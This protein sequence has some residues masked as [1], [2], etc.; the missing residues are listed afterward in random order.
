MSDGNM[1]RAVQGHATN[2]DAAVMNGNGGDGGVG[3]VG[4]VAVAGVAV[5]GNRGG[6]GEAGN[7]AAIGVGRPA[8]NNR[9]LANDD[10]EPHGNKRAPGK[11]RARPSQGTE[12]VVYRG[13]KGKFGH[14]FE[15]FKFVNPPGKLCY[16]KGNP[17]QKGEKAQHAVGRQTMDL[18]ADTLDSVEKLI[19]ESGVVSLDCT[20]WPQCMKAKE[21]K[22]R[23]EVVQGGYRIDLEMV[24]VLSAGSLPED[25]RTFFDLHAKLVSLGHSALVG[26]RMS[27]ARAPIGLNEAIAEAM[28]SQLA[29][30]AAELQAANLHA[31]S[32]AHSQPVDGVTH[33]TTEMLRDAL[34]QDDGSDVTSAVASYP[35]S[36][37][38]T[39]SF[40]VQSTMHSRMRMAER[41]ITKGELQRAVKYAGHLARPGKPSVLGEPTLLIE[42]DGVVYCTDMSKKI[43]I[44][45]WRVR[46]QAE[47]GQ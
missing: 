41:E 16:A 12:V 42:Y 15:E 37:A 14:R 46:E 28:D 22:I 40:T 20:S 9:H 25:Q 23:L 10:A 27:F 13:H 7:D 38:A 36:I 24:D 45:N 2:G 34:S 5:D 32:R 8:N 4:N 44:S 33:P 31:S 29:A 26:N 1:E 3:G 43:A 47:H 11:K 17:P 21:G 30:D 39:S 18:Q 6:V 19:E 35:H